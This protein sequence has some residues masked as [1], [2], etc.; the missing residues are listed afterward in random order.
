MDPP[1][2]AAIEARL[3]WTRRDA[4]PNQ[5]DPEEG[6][7]D[8]NVWAAVAGRGFGK[9]RME[10][11]W[12]WWQA[13]SDPNTRTHVVARTHSDLDQTMFN[14][15]SG[16]ANIVPPAIVE[17]FTQN[18]LYMRLCNGS[19]IIGFSAEKPSAL[20]GPQCH[21][22]VADEFCFWERR[23]AAM[24]NLLFGLRLRSPTGRRSARLLIGS[25]PLPVE[26]I[27]E[28]VRQAKEGGH[29]VALSTGS[30]YDNRSNLDD[31][32]FERHVKRYEGTRLGQ[33]EIFGRILEDAPGA[34][35]TWAM[36]QQAQAQYRLEPGYVSVG[37]D[38]AAS[39]NAS[40]DETGIV[41]AQND[42]GMPTGTVLAD[43]SLKG[44]PDTWGK[45]VVQAYDTW[46]ADDVVVEVNNGGDMA[47]HVIRSAAKALHA[48]GLRT[49]KE[50]VIRKVH[51]S[52]GKVI[53]AEPISALYEQGRVHHMPGLIELEK[54]MTS[55]SPIIDDTSPDRMDALVWA[56]T[57]VM[58]DARQTPRVSLPPKDFMRPNAWRIR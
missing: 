5:L 26:E 7:E 23:A 16:F 17:H 6:D 53:R 51:A 18:P 19:E 45:T 1:E 15:Q 4:R 22:A 31:S 29:G 56:M 48:D 43:L 39:N 13:W 50:I 37:V 35:W 42:R 49:S 30:T 24:S 38:P 52:R 12:A 57:R 11:E 55:W 2:L 41:V 28:I 47:E 46:D 8:W 54:Q 21:Y 36:I 14:G 10:V 40:S 3:R 58:I 33:Q 34:L 32:F 27:K 44:S 9:T 20:R 25:S